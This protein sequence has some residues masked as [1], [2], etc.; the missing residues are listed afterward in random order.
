MDESEG[1]L[2]KKLVDAP[3]EDLL[4]VGVYSLE[5]AIEAQRREHLERDLPH[6]RAFVLRCSRDGQITKDERKARIAPV[7]QR[8]DADGRPTALTAL[9]DDPSFL[10]PEPAARRAFEDLLRQ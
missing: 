4:P 6:S 9:L 8:G 1:R 7:R 5:V 10:I 3:A 2:C